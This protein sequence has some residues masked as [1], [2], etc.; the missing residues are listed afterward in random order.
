MQP[1]E[2]RLAALVQ[3]L[4]AQVVLCHGVFAPNTKHRNPVIV[5][6][7]PAPP[8][9]AEPHEAQEAKPRGAM[10]WMQRLRG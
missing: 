10:T 8:F 1:G 3:R 4:R 6:A 2:T 9:T 5:T 7:L